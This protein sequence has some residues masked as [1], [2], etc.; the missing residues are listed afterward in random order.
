MTSLTNA[1]S[2]PEVLWQPTAQRVRASRIQE[3]RDWLG[4]ERGLD[5]PDY[6]SLWQWSVTDL[7]GFWD[8]IAGFFDVRF[9]DRPRQVLADE[10]MPGASWFPG[11]S[12]NYAEHALRE[13]EG[14]GDNDLAVVFARE[15]GHGEEIT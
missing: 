13:G 5:L 12:L 6:R 10:E 2:T 4:K 7:A 15:D 8:A 1:D 14:K 3:F 11:S 9:H